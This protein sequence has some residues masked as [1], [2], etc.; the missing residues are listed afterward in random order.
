MQILNIFFEFSEWKRYF[1]LLTEICVHIRY[2]ANHCIGVY[3]CKSFQVP[4]PNLSKNKIWQNV[5]VIRSIYMWN[6]QERK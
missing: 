3:T 6:V 2:V 5:G 1:I 4:Y